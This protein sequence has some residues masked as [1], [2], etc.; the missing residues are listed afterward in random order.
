MRD[1]F[2]KH[3]RETLARR[4]NYHCSNCWSL[5]SGPQQE[6]TK[7]VS[8]DVAAHITAAAVSGPRYDPQLSSVERKSIQNGIWLCQNCAKLID[9]DPQRYSVALLRQWKS[10]AEER[11]HQELSHGGIPSIANKQAIAYRFIP[12]ADLTSRDAQYNIM[13]IG[14][15]IGKSRSAVES[16]FGSCNEVNVVNVGS[17]SSIPGGGEIRRYHYEGY[18]LSVD[19]DLNDVVQGIQ[20]KDFQK[21]RYILAD[22]FEI[23]HRLGISVGPLP[24]ITSPIKW[25][26]SNY[27]GYYM[28]ISLNEIGVINIVRAH[29]VT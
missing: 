15:V 24:D 25:V 18:L 10:Q 27:Q 20:F 9:S 14:R 4:V 21:H 6:P 28:S 29:R 8:I 22:Y 17:L 11:V 3:T 12:G 7:T 13:Y 19:Y 2:D 23:F 5:T 26:W 16:F 1:D